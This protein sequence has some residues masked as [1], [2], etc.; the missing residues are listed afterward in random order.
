MT[1]QHNVPA[2]RAAGNHS[3]REHPGLFPL[4]DAEADHLI[5]LARAALIGRGLSTSYDASTG[6]LAVIP[7]P[8]PESSH[9][10]DHLGGA[11]FGLGNL[12]R[13]VNGHPRQSWS[14]LVEEHFD[15]L[16]ASILRPPAGPTDPE[17][18]LYLR[19]AATSSV[20]AKWTADLPEFLPGL[21]AVPASNDNGTFA[22]HFDPSTFGLTWTEA[23]RIALANLN[24]LPD[25]VSYIDHDGVQLAVL[26][27]TTWAASR[28]L[29]LDT[30]LRESLQVENPPYGVLVA[31]PTR[32]LLLIHVIRDLSILPAISAMLRLTHTAYET[33]PGP[34]TP[35]VYLVD[36]TGWH[37]ATTALPNHPLPYHLTPHLRALTQTLAHQEQSPD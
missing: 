33:S 22:L 18:Q 7:P 12:A 8:D 6:S 1:T 2:E 27:D 3:D 24:L 9:P 35:T 16:M 19:L 28:A 37:P 23:H 14:R 36:P 26:S 11:L 29:V 17:R 13:T 34:L 5:H 30:V 20:P 25:S 4:T 15:S 21:V 31:L 10:P 32:H